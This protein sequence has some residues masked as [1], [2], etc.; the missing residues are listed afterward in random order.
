MTV[1]M[2][3]TGINVDRKVE[4]EDDPSRCVPEPSAA[5]IAV[6][7]MKALDKRD[8]LGKMSKG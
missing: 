2:R 4:A 6:L 7:L 8:H 5:M 1:V 3:R